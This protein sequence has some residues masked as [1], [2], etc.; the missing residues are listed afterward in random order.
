MSKPTITKTHTIASEVKT[1]FHPPSAAILPVM[2]SPYKNLP[3]RQ[4]GHDPFGLL[5]YLNVSE[6]NNRVLRLDRFVP[7]LNDYLCEI[8]RTLTIRGDVLVIEMSIRD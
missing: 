7:S 6:M 3:S 8:C 2:V 4:I 5:A 1:V